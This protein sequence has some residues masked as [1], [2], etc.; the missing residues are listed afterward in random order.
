MN[1]ELKE[2]VRVRL[3]QTVMKYGYET[4]SA[5]DSN[6]MVDKFTAMMEKHGDMYCPCHVTQNADTLC[7]CKFMRQYGACRC[8]LFKKPEVQK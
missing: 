4:R 5:E 8:G 3:V 6:R 1:K 7:P 2:D